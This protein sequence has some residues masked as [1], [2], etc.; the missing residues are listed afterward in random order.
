MH[1]LSIS[2]E[3]STPLTTQLLQPNEDMPNTETA[4]TTSGKYV[5]QP[6]QVTSPS[7]DAAKPDSSSQEITLGQLGGWTDVM[8]M[9]ATRDIVL[10]KEEQTKAQ[11]CS[12]GLSETFYS[13]NSESF[14]P[15]ITPDK[16]D[17]DYISFKDIMDRTWSI[18]LDNLSITNIEMEQAYLR[19]QRTSSPIHPIPATSSVHSS[20][21]S[22]TEI[23]DTPNDNEKDNPTYGHHKKPRHSIQPGHRPSS[24]RIAVQ[25]LITK[26]RGSKLAHTKN[27]VKQKS[28]NRMIISTN[29]MIKPNLGN[30]QQGMEI[31]PNRN[32][33]V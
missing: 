2:T 12:L 24:A 30:P 8:H 5:P 15:V 33:L 26:T 20:T 14:Y 27:D 25:K 29:R 1:D 21:S 13:S 32:S 6:D 16:D 10:G 31:K 7:V 17:V 3:V 11:L 22:S 19:S 9:K 28:T 4:I 23:I 18:P